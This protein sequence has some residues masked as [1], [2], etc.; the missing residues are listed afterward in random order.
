MENDS[1]LKTIT[2]RLKARGLTYDDLDKYLK[3]TYKSVKKTSDAEKLIYLYRAHLSEPENWIVQ[4][5][6]GTGER[7]LLTREMP[8]RFADILA[9]AICRELGI[10]FKEFKRNR[11]S[12]PRQSTIDRMVGSLEED[13]EEQDLDF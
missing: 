10:E 3:K 1:V 6:R 11:S 8:I 7:K 5:T 4:K 9:R 2:G 13:L 12:G